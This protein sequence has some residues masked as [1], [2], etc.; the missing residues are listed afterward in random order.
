MPTKHLEEIRKEFDTT[1]RRM[2][3]NLN[4]EYLAMEL[5]K[6]SQNICRHS[7]ASWDA[8]TIEDV[9]EFVIEALCERMEGLGKEAFEKEGGKT[10]VSYFVLEKELKSVAI[11]P[12]IAMLRDL[13]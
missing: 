10:V 9:E 2:L 5:S 11:R 3:D 8:S 7:V 4:I 13:A 6:T 1:P 12:W